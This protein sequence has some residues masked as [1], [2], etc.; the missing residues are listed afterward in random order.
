MTAQ[1]HLKALVRARMAHTG[2]SYT[3][4]RRH[5]VDARPAPALAPMGEFRAHD[6]HCMVVQFTPD[7]AHLLSG[8]FGGQ[9]RIW[10]PDGELVG[11]LS[12]HESSVNV[13]RVSD[14]GSMAITAAS[15]KTVRL[16]DIPARKEIAILG[17]HKKQ[18][19]ALDLDVPRDRAWSGGHDGRLQA[20][21]LSSHELVESFDLGGP[22]TSVA[23]RVA[24]GTLAATT[25]GAGISVRG[26]DGAELTRLATEA[27]V[28]MASAWSADGS[29]MIA[30]APAGATLW[31]TEG[32]EPV[33]SLSSGGGGVLPV[34]LSRDGSRIALGWDNH[35]ALWSADETEPPAIV[36]GLPK[37]VYGLAFSHRG[38]S[39]AMAAA[40]GRVR[41]WRVS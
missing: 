13:I 15:D 3:A 31:E 6:K 7:D 37:G 38:T 14:D 23:V 20:W 8:G 25:V 11:E 22:V 5:L 40:D 32:W 4:A 39:L 16:W 28:T 35:V 2:E 27:K 26:S 29:F 17:R 41:S 34:A 19:L 21:S 12:G 30:S 18:V 1:K 36:A 33:R 10:T 9:A 24:D